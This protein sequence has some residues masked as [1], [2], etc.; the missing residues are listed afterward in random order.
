RNRHK[1]QARV[2]EPD[3]EPSG[4]ESGAL[5]RL[6]EEDDSNEF[7]SVQLRKT[8]F[9]DQLETAVR[10]AA[11]SE[12]ER[13]GRS[14]RDCPYIG[15]WMGFYRTRSSRHIEAALHRYA[16]ES[17]GV[18]SANEYIP[19]IARR[20]R[21]A[22]SVWAATSRITG[23]PDELASRING[24][25]GLASIDAFISTT[26]V[27]TADS[28]PQA[29]VVTTRSGSPPGN[30]PA[31][32]D[33]NEA[34]AEGAQNISSQLGP[35]GS[36]DTGL[37]SKME[38]AFGHDFSRVRVHTDAR[39]AALS[40]NLNARAFTVGSDIAFATGEYRPGN[41][42]GEALIAHELAHVVQQ[43]AAGGSS[44]T[45]REET[46]YDRLEEDADGSA[47]GAIASLWGGIKGVLAGAARNA[48]PA[49]SSGLGLQRCHRDKETCSVGMKTV[50]IDLIKLRGSTAT[51]L[52]SLD[53]ANL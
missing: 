12:L 41:I 39:A 11:D 38:S 4:Y 21:Q 28:G 17:R 18:R 10:A 49:L 15:R 40:A 5:R 53:I 36:L 32:N 22:A 23:L 48:K 42:V 31:A 52:V 27:A 14:A 47:F 25:G 51:P 44:S 45:L 6:L 43:E 34:A 26:P 2:T 29:A 7:A 20:V 46:E 1:G 33:S 8:D 16:P 24:G 19:V 37:R 3:S 35:G 13:V 9:L 30:T 50:S